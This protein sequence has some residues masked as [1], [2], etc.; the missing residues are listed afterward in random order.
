MSALFALFAHE[1]DW[2]SARKDEPMDCSCGAMV[3]APS[4]EAVYQHRADALIA[5]GWAPAEETD[6]RVERIARA[7]HDEVLDDPPADLWLRRSEPFRE[8]WRRQARAGLA[9]LREEAE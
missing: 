9:A 3:P 2:Y 8:G 5:A 6:E 7:M 4:W 1:P